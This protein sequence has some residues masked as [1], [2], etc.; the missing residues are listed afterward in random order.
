MKERAKQGIVILGA[1]LFAEEIAEYI[2]RI[3]AYDLVGFVEGVNREKCGNGLLGLPVF[4]VEDIGSLALSCKAVCAVGSTRRKPFIEQATRHGLEFVTIVHPGAEVFRTATLGV[5]TIV[6]PGSIIAASAT[7][8]DHVIINRGALLGHHVQVGDYV[9]ISPGANVAGKVKIGDF[10]Y[11][12]IGAVILDGIAI[13]DGSV[14]GA[15]SVVTKD[16]P[17]S[18]QVVGIPAKKSKQLKESY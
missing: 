16:V 18:V 12:G 17:S 2:S 13:G 10:C 8:G 11:I 6:G 5:G 3:E 9:T 7:I 14:V 15:G 4:W 1:S